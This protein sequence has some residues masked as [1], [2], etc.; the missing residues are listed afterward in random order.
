M[1]N[2][3][4]SLFHNGYNKHLESINGIKFTPREIDIISCLL[5]GRTP[6]VIASFL[7]ISPRTIETHIRNIMLKVECNSREGIINFI[8]KTDKGTLIKKHY[9]NLLS[10][11]SFKQKLKDVSKLSRSAPASILLLIEKDLDQIFLMQHIESYLLIAGI[12]VELWLEKHKE[13]P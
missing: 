5:S 12:N 3:Q 4:D 2:G 11:Y 10:D 8:E 7:S 13:K 9:L 6:K 1:K